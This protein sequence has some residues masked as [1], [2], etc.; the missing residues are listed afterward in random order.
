MS[1]SQ[2]ENKWFKIF[3]NNLIIAC[4]ILGFG[5]L[6]YRLSQDNEN[7]VFPIYIPA[8]ISLYFLYQKHKLNW[9]GIGFGTFGEALINLFSMGFSISNNYT[10][11]LL[12]VAINIS[13]ANTLQP[14]TCVFLL[15]LIARS[16]DIFDNSNET[17]LFFIAST[18][19]CI[20]AGILGPLGMISGGIIPF[21]V[22][23][24]SA[25]SWFIS[26]LA[27]ILILFPLLFFTEEAIRNPKQFDRWVELVIFSIF[28]IGFQLIFLQ[29]II[30]GDKTPELEYLALPFMI[31]AVLR[32][33]KLISVWFIFSVTISMVLSLYFGNN[34]F[35]HGNLERSLLYLQFFLMVIAITNL[36]LNA[37]VSEKNASNEKLL[38]YTEN[39]ENEVKETV[40]ELKILK[41][42]LPICAHC[43]KI[44]DSTGSWQNL[45]NYIDSHSEAKFSHG[46][47]PECSDI[48]LQESK[49]N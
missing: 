29:R 11:S 21:T 3:L 41:G 38:K 1:E 39:L 27:G 48:Y 2:L 18:I 45:E 37:V 35:S 47:C 30:F 16:E 19:G 40:S 13:I 49:E 24:A 33:S 4:I 15:N 23:I 14:L 8:G 6:S 28:A 17:I 12:I 7:I 25:W 31:W 43:K 32:F 34:P 10:G 9:V 36:S 22:Y 26:D 44:K 46:L 20:I 5:V 42:F